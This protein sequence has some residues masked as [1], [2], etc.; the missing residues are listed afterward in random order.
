MTPL[1]IN[2]HHKVT[3]F[4]FLDAWKESYGNLR[5]KGSLV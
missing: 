5:L 4:K 2:K 3:T 1:V